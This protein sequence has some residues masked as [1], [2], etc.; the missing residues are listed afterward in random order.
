MKSLL[1]VLSDMVVPQFDVA[2]ALS[3]VQSKAEEQIEIETAYKWG[4]RAMA[5]YQLY[6]QTKNVKWLLQAE[7][8]R[9]EAIEHASL[10]KD[11]GNTLRVVEEAL[12][13]YKLTLKMDGQNG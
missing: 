2:A 4:S 13:K 12:D 11:S 6:S 9:H 1:K 5:C 3:E 8:Y 10:A 7:D